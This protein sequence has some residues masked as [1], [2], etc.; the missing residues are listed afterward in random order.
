MQGIGFAFHDGP[1]REKHA[2]KNSFAPDTSVDPSWKT[3]LLQVRSFL[4]ALLDTLVTCVQRALAGGLS[5]HL[6][7]SLLL[8]RG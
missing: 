7:A 6:L 2:T 3:T 5:G 8:C 1:R 4:A